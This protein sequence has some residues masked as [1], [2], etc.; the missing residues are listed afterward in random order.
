MQEHTRLCTKYA[1]SC[2][3]RTAIGI[4]FTMNNISLPLEPR[5]RYSS[6]VAG[7]TSTSTSRTNDRNHS[8]LGSRVNHRINTIAARNIKLR[9]DTFSGKLLGHRQHPSIT[10]RITNLK[11]PYHRNSHGPLVGTREGGPL[12][13]ELLLCALRRLAANRHK[14]RSSQVGYFAVLLWPPRWFTPPPLRSISVMG[15]RYPTVPHFPFKHNTNPN[16]S[17]PPRG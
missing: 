5:W 10:V 9:R 4:Y 2:A 13:G 3:R 15:I 11:R 1:S 8:S 6:D 17:M 14:K 12:A 7:S 16:Y